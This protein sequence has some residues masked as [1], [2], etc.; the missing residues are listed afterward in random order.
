LPQYELYVPLTYNS[1]APDFGRDIEP[2]KLNQTKDEL[3]RQ[4]GPLTIIPTTGSLEG[5]WVSPEGKLVRDKIRIFRVVVNFDADQWFANYNIVVKDR[6]KQ[7]EVLIFVTE[8][9]TV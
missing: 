6:F 1:G 7:R 3:I 9:Y 8:G 5:N 4:F 2:S